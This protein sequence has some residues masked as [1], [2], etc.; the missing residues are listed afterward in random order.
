MVSQ[1]SHSRIFLL[2]RI[3]ENVM[4]LVKNRSD[5]DLASAMVRAMCSSFNRDYICSYSQRFSFEKMA[6]K[7]CELYRSIIR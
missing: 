4:I 6:E 2:Q 7:Y 1:M 3:D 5:H